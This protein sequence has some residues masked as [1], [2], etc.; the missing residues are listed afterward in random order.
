MLKFGFEVEGFAFDDSGALTIPPKGWPHDGFPGLIELRTE[1]G[2]DLDNQW[3][4]LERREFALSKSFKKDKCTASFLVHEHKFSPKQMQELRRTRTF[5]KNIVDV[6]NIYGKAPRDAR[7][8]TLASFQINISN[9]LQAERREQIK[10]ET[11]VFPARYGLLDVPKIVRALDEEFKSEIKAAGRQP[12]M[13]AIKDSI[14]LEYRSLPNFIY[15]D[16]NHGTLRRLESVFEKCE[17]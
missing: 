17:N 2:A 9:C 10:G 8:R 1:G 14:R 5:T 6:Q 15:Y 12:G 3:F 4:D 11:T 13:Y 16:G 7:G